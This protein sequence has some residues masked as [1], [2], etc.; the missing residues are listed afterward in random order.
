MTATL[1]I[2]PARYEHI[3]PIAIHLRDAD[4]NELRDIYGQ[5]PFSGLELL[6]KTSAQAWTFMFDGVPAGMFGVQPM[7]NGYGVMVGMLATGAVDENAASFVRASVR[8]RDQLLR[9]YRRIMN[10]IDA[11]NTTTIRWL[12]WLGFEISEPFIAGPKEALVRKF[13]MR[14]KVLLCA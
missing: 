7:P 14:K 6:F 13:E 5:T 4:R 2:I 8:W 12:G 9:R 3:A 11:N 10:L 1:S